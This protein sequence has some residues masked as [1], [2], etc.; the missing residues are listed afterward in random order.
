MKKLSLIMITRSA[1]IAALYFCATV[2][3][4]PICFGPMQL[5]IAE[6]LTLLPFVFP[7][8]A[9][10]L[11]IG[12]ALANISSPFGL[13]DVFVGAGVTLI[14]GLLTSKC[15]NIFL[16]TLPPILL[17]AF[18]IPLIWVFSGVEEIYL[19]AAIYLLVSQ[20]LIIILL[21]IPVARTISAIPSIGAFERYEKKKK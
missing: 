15:K 3:T 4:A 7:E 1:V 6:A 18:I 9:I 8:T 2:F 11:A 12:C 5:R 21:G 19:T 10:G 13:V 20:A 16:A 14:A 17:N